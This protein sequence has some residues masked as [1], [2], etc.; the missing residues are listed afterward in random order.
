MSSGTGIIIIPVGKF[1]ELILWEMEDCIDDKQY[2]EI[3]IEYSN[4]K[5]GLEGGRGHIYKITDNFMSA[6]GVA[7]LRFGKILNLILDIANEE[8]FN[9]VKEKLEN[10]EESDLLNNY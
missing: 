2:Y 3:S 6:P 5:P 4:N 1:I 7:I 8:D 10:F 9:I